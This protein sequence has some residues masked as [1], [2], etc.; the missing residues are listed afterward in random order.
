MAFAGGH[1]SWRKRAAES[2]ALW[3]EL[4]APELASL[5]ATIE[6]VRIAGV[7]CHECLPAA[8]TQANGPV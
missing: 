6:T 4:A 3:D 5:K 1:R 2:N 7:T 8:G